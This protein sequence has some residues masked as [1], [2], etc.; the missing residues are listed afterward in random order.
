ME[1]SVSQ[2]QQQKQPLQRDD[3]LS[4][5][6]ETNCGLKKSLETSLNR[7]LN[8]QICLTAA[9]VVVVVVVDC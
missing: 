8:M 1:F 9:F 2:S 3:S 4:S 7:F 5:F 6:M